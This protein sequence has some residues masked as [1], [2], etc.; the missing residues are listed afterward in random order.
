MNVVNV[1]TDYSIVNMLVICEYK[2]LGIQVGSIS[3]TLH[4]LLSAV[5]E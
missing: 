2:E 3:T 4:A 5:V 1:N